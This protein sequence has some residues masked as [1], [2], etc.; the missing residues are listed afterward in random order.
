MERISN[1]KIWAG[2]EVITDWNNTEDAKSRGNGTL[3][4]KNM[5]T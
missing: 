4:V 3:L 5:A 2:L 1:E